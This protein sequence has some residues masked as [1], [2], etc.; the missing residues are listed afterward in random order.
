MDWLGISY[1]SKINVPD[2]KLGQENKIGYFSQKQNFSRGMEKKKR[3]SCAARDGLERGSCDRYAI[4]TTFY[5][6][7]LCFVLLYER[8]GQGNLI[9]KDR[10]ST[11]QTRHSRH[12]LQSICELASVHLSRISQLFLLLSNTVSRTRADMTAAGTDMVHRKLWFYSL[13]LLLTTGSIYGDNSDKSQSKSVKR[14]ADTS[15]Y[16]DT[17]A[18]ASTYDTDSEGYSAGSTYSGY[19]ASYGY[20]DA[21]SAGYGGSGLAAYGS[22]SA[23]YAAAGGSSYSSPATAYSSGATAYG[24]GAAAYG[25]GA[26]AYGSG[27]TDYSQ[28]AYGQGAYGLGAYGSGAA[29]YA[30]PASYYSAGSAAYGSPAYG[31]SSGSDYGS[32]YQDLHGHLISQHVEVSRPVPVPIY[33]AVPVPIPHPVAVPVPQ[34]I[35]I[36]VPQPIAVQ[37][38]VPVPVIKTVAY[39]VEKPVPYPVE[40]PVK[41]TVEK[42]VPYPVSKPYAVHVPVYKVKHIYHDTKHHYPSSYYN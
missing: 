37:V 3:T 19:G 2:R 22:P 4:I 32:G 17:N 20:A 9:L 8:I 5:R 33:K 34:P 16:S 11:Q 21:G 42:K 29:G 38:P 26:S 7:V 10:T 28:G 23:A 18:Q 35:P 27:A 31:S 12:L 40:K 30:S 1:G 15:Q 25:Q 39:P 24:S 6:D 41:V 14:G 36:H 13:C